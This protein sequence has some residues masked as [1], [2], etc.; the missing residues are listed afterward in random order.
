MPAANNHKDG[1]SGQC[2]IANSVANRATVCQSLWWPIGPASNGHV[3]G[4]LWA[5]D[6]V[7]CI[8]APSAQVMRVAIRANVIVSLIE[9]KYSPHHWGS[10]ALHIYRAGR[11]R[12]YGV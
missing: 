5:S 12:R 2:L 6:C 7:V 1:Q 3:G 11:G 10:Q 9:E 8:M 4:Q